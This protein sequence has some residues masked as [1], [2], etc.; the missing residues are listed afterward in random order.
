MSLRMFTEPGNSACPLPPAFCWTKFG[1]EAG[2]FVAEILARKERERAANGGTFLWGVGT[3][4]RPSLVALLSQV[5]DPEVLFSPMRCRPARRDVEPGAVVAWRSA[6][7]LDG[8]AYAI[9]LA[10][11]VTSRMSARQR[12][13]ALVCHSETPLPVDGQPDGN[14]PWVDDSGIRNLLTGRPVG[15][16][17]VTSVVRRLPISGAPRYRVAFRAR[18]S[19]PYLLALSDA[20]RA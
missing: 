13:F 1:V 10:S 4:I 5:P 14:A 2:E 16:S 9:P 8:Q 19:P 20:E 17:Q 15:S 18:L 11:L 7:G 12:H 3:S 6:T